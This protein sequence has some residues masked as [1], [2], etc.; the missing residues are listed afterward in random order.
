[1]THDEFRRLVVER[2]GLSEVDADRI[3]EAVLLALADRLDPF[4][5]KEV[6][7][8]LPW[9]LKDW[10]TGAVRS[11]PEDFGVDE[12]VRRAAEKAKLPADQAGQA[13]RAVMTALRAATSAGEFDDMLA[14]LP[15]E[16]AG[17]VDLSVPPAGP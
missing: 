14:L 3:T 6:A 12:L 15:P 10:L 5:T 11:R 13:V 8:Q 9:P 17:L 7:A 4:E 1:M 16:Y 2:T